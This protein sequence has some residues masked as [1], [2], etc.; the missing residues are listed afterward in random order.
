[1]QIDR[2]T[3]DPPSIHLAHGKDRAAGDDAIANN[4]QPSE[5]T[6]DVAA[7]GGVIHVRH[8]QTKVL[9]SYHPEGDVALN[10]RQVG[11]L[12]RVSDYLRQAQTLFM[13]ELLVPASPMQL[14]RVEGNKNAYDLQVRPP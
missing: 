9:V 1:M 3:L 7:D 8:H 13:F 12:T 6:E 5:H 4:W 10:Q 2:Q 11:R 14:E